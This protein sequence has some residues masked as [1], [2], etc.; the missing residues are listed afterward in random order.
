[1]SVRSVMQHLYPRL[2]ALHDLEDYIALPNPTTGRISMPAIMRDTHIYMEA[3]GIYLIDNEDNMIFWI[4]SSVSPQLLND[5]FGVDD[6]MS[7][8]PHLNHFPHLETRFS[9]QV[10]NI[11]A[12]RY[13]QR[14][15]TPKLSIARQNL[16][17]AEV[18]F[19]DMLVEDQNNANMSYVD[20]L[21][22]VHKQIGTAL[23]GG[24]LSGATSLRAGSMAW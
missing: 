10:R 7:L 15:Y 9:T 24:S 14:G 4:G 16:D 2:L 5:L 19:S 6:V 8:E 22:V 23:T 21:T 17:A 12:Y 3:N 1:M 18:E 13:A 20:Y 11:L